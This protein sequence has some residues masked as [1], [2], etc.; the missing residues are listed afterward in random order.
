[1]NR[2]KMGEDERNWRSRLA[3]IMHSKELI[4]G[5]LAIREHTCG[6]AGC[7]CA[8]GEKH[9]SF[10]LSRSRRGKPQQ[11]YVPLDMS[12]E[13]KAWAK[14]YREVKRLLG[15]TSDLYWEKL[16]KRKG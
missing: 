6:K 2:S 5:T 4:R 7:K 14:E 16:K 8:R 11:I 10:Y 12:Q 15:K 13:V 1:M 9:T 3:Q